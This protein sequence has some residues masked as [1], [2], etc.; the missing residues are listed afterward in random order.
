MQLATRVW[1]L[2]HCKGVVGTEQSAV[3]GQQ[4]PNGEQPN[5][6]G[7]ST[8]LI[9]K[10]R[11]QGNVGALHQEA[12]IPP[13]D[14]HFALPE[15]DQ[16]LIEQGAKSLE[17]RLN[18]AP[19]SIIRAND[20]I[21]INGKTLTTVVAVRKYA[22]LQSVLEAENVNALLPQSS[23]VGSGA[24]NAVAAA[25]RHYRHFFSAEEEEHY[26]LVVF[27]LAVPVSTSTAPKSQEEWSGKLLASLSSSSTTG[28]S[29]LSFL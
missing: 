13:A 27:E 2:A 20:R 29:N 6:F 22:L 18:V 28:P 5:Q 1:N 14:Y 17:I 3:N 24:F 7:A 21:T 11:E 16:R 26:G 23:F 10:P 25:E 8:T 4:H 12:S 9:E 19:Y 15:Q